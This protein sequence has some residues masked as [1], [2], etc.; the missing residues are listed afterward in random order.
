MTKN[1]TL[2]YKRYMIIDHIPLLGI[3]QKDSTTYQSLKQKN[4]INDHQ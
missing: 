3:M 2:P 1:Q 4:D